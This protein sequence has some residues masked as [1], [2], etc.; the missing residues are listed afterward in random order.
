MEAKV[1]VRKL[2]VL[3][4]RI[5]QTIDALNQ[6]RLSV[7]GLGHTGFQGQPMNPYSYLTQGYGMQQ[8]F[9]FGQGFPGF[10]GQQGGF[11]GMTGLGQQGYGQQGLQGFPGLTPGFGFQHSPFTPQYTPFS[12]F[13]HPLTNP[14]LTQWGGGPNV[15]VPWGNLG[16][17]LFHSGPDVIERQILE[18]KAAD[19]YRITQTFPFV[20]S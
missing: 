19:P 3:N 17:G 13:V 20:L 9:G 12:P 4:D 1:D 7:H 2:Q 18:I 11:S 8:P 10:G 15:G 5:N 6:V 16:G 14:L